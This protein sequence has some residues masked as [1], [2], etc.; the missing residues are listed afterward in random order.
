[1]HF[2]LFTKLI[3]HQVPHLARQLTRLQAYNL[4]GKFLGYVLSPSNI[5]CYIQNSINVNLAKQK[6]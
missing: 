1:M 6:Y 3:C 2:R 5:P 4:I